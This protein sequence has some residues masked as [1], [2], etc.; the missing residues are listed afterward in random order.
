MDRIVVNVHDLEIGDEY[1]GGTSFMV[2]AA[3]VVST[4]PQLFPHD[5]METDN[6]CVVVGVQYQDGARGSRLYGPNTY[7]QVNRPDAWPQ[8][9]D[10]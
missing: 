8:R 7:L 5:D 10:L 4:N 1:P 6:T 2:I 3:P 9:D